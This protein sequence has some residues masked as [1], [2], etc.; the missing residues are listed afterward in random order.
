MGKF[1]GLF[2]V[3]CLDGYPL[4]L[5]TVVNGKVSS[6]GFAARNQCLN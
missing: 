2:I 1:H 4:V 5:K 3:W 6:V